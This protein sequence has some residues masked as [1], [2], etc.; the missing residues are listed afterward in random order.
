LL[1]E[2]IDEKNIL[3]TGNSVIDALHYVVEQTEPKEITALKQTGD[4]RLFCDGSPAQAGQPLENICRAIR[5][6][7]HERM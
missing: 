3:V 4:R 7:L 1:R 5:K 2:G 6:R